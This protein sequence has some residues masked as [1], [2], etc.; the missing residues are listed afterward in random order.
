MR[1]WLPLL[2]LVLALAGG[3][4]YRHH[5]ADGERSGKAGKQSAPVPVTVAPVVIRDV[6][7]WLEAVGRGTA[8]ET[9]TLKA[10][11]DG[12]VASVPF[13]EGQHVERGEVLVRLDP[14]DFEARVGQAQANLARDEAQL[15][16]ARADLER[17]QALRQSGFVS[18][19]RLGEVRANLQAAQ[20]GVLAA[21][22]AL[23]LARLQLGYATIRAPIAGVT[24]AKLV[25]PGAGVK[26]NDTSLA[27]IN[28]VRP[29]HIS[30]AVPERHL[31]QL[32]AAL[33]RGGLMAHILVG[34]SEVAAGAVSFLD[35]AVDTASG[36]LLLRAT[37]ANADAALTPGQ[38]VQVRLAL[39][40]WTAAATVPA[41]AVQQGPEGSYV[42]VV[43]ADQGVEQRR[44]TLAESS[45]GMAVITAG[46]KAGE[47]V[48]TDG[49]LRLTPKSKVKAVTK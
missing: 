28:R 5:A 37:V 42:Y 20:A 2:L 9:V 32:R 8:Y 19:E 43:R 13:S 27:V 34:G 45:A 15:A 6:P 10:R 21:Q 25:F 29:L 41:E 23:E 22:S 17:Y 46:L 12:Q 33:G 40:T 38:F 3:V 14:A 7:Q 44:V 11:V 24:G 48:V 47:R 49:H 18:E 1:F 39:A 36:T 35:N 4:Y 30:F 16:K 31:P 26:A